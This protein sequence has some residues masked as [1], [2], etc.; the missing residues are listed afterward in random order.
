MNNEIQK[1]VNWFNDA[2]PNPT[3]EDLCVQIGC[4]YEEVSEMA[5]T[6]GDV[7]SKKM[8]EEDSNYY[9]GNDHRFLSAL[10]LTINDKESKIKLIDDLCDQIF[11]AV[12]VGQLAGFDMVG[13]LQEVIRS[14]DSKRL[15]NG[16]FLFDENGKISKKHESFSAPDLRPFI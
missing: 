6:L 12:G 14:N 11:T 8:L 13:A 15:P 1:I 5:E 10:T 9:K 16:E 4:H 3:I 7:D 2:K